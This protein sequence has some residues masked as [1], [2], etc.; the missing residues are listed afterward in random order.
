MALF[1]WRIID[2]KTLTI[3]T[4][5]ALSTGTAMRSEL[6]GTV[7]NSIDAKKREYHMRYFLFLLENIGLLLFRSYHP[8]LIAK[9][10]IQ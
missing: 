7:A 5:S 9:V 6:E 3:A 10:A 1:G 8:Y 2:T 4:V